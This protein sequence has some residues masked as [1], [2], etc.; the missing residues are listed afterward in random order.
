MITNQHISEI[1]IIRIMGRVW[2]ISPDDIPLDVKF[3]DILEWDS[4]G[5]V[6]LL[7]ELEAEFSIDIS[8]EVLTELTTME[9]IIDHLK[10]M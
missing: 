4:M 5:H 3:G 1:E 9:A 2:E 7:A 10:R 8:Y 6:A